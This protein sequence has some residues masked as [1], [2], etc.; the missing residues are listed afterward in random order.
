MR[1]RFLESIEPFHMQKAVQCFADEAMEV[2]AK[3]KT[4]INTPGI[5]RIQFKC[6]TFV[7]CGTPVHAFRSRY[8]GGRFTYKIEKIIPKK[9][10]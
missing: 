6:H 4:Y 7:G 9:E 2:L 1:L 5:T 3:P 10:G 8:N